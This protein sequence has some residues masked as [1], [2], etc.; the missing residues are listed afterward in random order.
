MKIAGS[1]HSTKT[2]GARR[3]LLAAHLSA[4]SRGEVIHRPV[5]DFPTHTRVRGR[6]EEVRPGNFLI[7]EGLFTFYWPTVR[8]VFH[9]KTFL[10]VPDSVCLEP[11]RARH[12]GTRPTLEFVVTAI[13]HHRPPGNQ[14]TSRPR[15]SLRIWCS[16]V[17]NQSKKQRE[18]F[19]SA[20]W[21]IW[22]LSKL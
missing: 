11:A 21:W 7:V 13:R 12:P 1:Q 16:T 22:Q 10:T 2:R 18:R 8:G 14:R 4:L 6:F 5:Y 17:N 15:G 19:T 20:S 9:L 3:W